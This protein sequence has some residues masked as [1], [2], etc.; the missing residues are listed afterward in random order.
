MR[1]GREFEGG[2]GAYR[3]RRHIPTFG[4]HTLAP[5]L[6]LSAGQCQG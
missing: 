1:E 6:M 4:T 2:G 3:V 5:K